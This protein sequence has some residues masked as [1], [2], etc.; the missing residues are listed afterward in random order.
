MN[1]VIISHNIIDIIRHN[2]TLIELLVVIAIIAILA[3]MLLPALSKARAAAQNTKCISNMRQTGTALIM[4]SV[5]HA[6]M[7]PEHVDHTSTIVSAFPAS[8]NEGTGPSEN[9]MDLILTYT[10]KEVLDGCPMLANDWRRSQKPAGVDWKFSYAYRFCDPDG[11]PLKPGPYNQ[12]LQLAT[13]KN[14][15]EA[16]LLM[17]IYGYG[18]VPLFTWYDYSYYWNTVVRSNAD[19]PEAKGIMF[20][21]GRRSNFVH[22]DGSVIATGLDDLGL[23]GLGTDPKFQ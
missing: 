14:P 18:T 15:S 11:T 2:F 3:S 20:A 17:H 5:E 21:H 8:Y 16:Y 9:W 1:Y 13:V 23:W 10:S 12:N 6:E 22:C 7:L 19:W 4:Y